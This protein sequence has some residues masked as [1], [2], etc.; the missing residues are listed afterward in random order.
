MFQYALFLKYISMGV[1]AKFDDFTEYVGRDNARPIEL[2]V[3]DIDY[4]KATK[5]EYMDYTDSYRDPLRRARRLLFGRKSRE[6]TEVI[7][8]FDEEVLKK[9]NAYISGYFQSEKYFLDIKDE[10]IK[11]FSFNENTKKS[12]MDLLAQNGVT[13]DGETVSVHIRRGDYLKFPGVY[14]NICTEDYYDRAIK[15]I[16][17]QVS[18]PRFLIFS[19]DT[20]WCEE[21]VKKYPELDMR[22]IK[23][24]DE[25]TGYIDM[26]LM[27]LC[28]HNIVANSS[29]SWWGAYLNRNSE[30]LVIAPKKWLNNHD[31]T[32]IYT[33]EMI[34]I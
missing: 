10:V 1:E 13:L 18:N 30:K 3:F 34:R 7:C 29:F 16:C 27:S 2:S 20:A 21:W 14:G 26:Y 22:L 24:T 15:Y 32:D 17:E 28:K 33:E 9:D 8:T 11:S 4:P 31:E 23:G 5:E 12:G 25:D 19:N 6:Y